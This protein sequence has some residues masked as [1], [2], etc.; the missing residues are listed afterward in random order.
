MTYEQFLHVIDDRKQGA[1]RVSVGLATNF[2]DIYHFLQFAQTMIDRSVP[3]APVMPSK[4]T[5]ETFSSVCACGY[6]DTRQEK[7]FCPHCGQSLRS[8]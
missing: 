4:L 1:L 7:R 2:S 8:M 5:P 6:H 3:P